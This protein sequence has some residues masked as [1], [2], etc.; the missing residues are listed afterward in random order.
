MNRKDVDKLIDGEREYQKMRWEAG[1]GGDRV[2]DRDKA[3]AEWVIYLDYLVNDAKAHVYD[4]RAERVKSI[5][6][7]I[8]AVAVACMEHNETQPRKLQ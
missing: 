6:R 4:L 2:P 3:V 1:G 8:A 5:I 7:K